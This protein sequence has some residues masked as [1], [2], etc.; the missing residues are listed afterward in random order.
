LST[1][2]EQLS[3]EARDKLERWAPNQRQLLAELLEDAGTDLQ[4]EFLDRAIAA[5]HTP[6]E[7]HAFAD[8]LRGMDDDEAF[9]ACTLDA[10]APEGYTVNQLLR[11]EA[12]PLYAYELKGG[13]LSPA[14]EGSEAPVT[15]ELTVD[16]ELTPPPMNPSPD[17]RVPTEAKPPRGEVIAQPKPAP[18]PLSVKD[19][20]PPGTMSP[21]GTLR[22]KDFATGSSGKLPAAAPLKESAPPGAMTPGGTKRPA[23][24]DTQP[25]PAF[26]PP[27]PGVVSHADTHPQPAFRPPPAGVDTGAH[28]PFRPPLAGTTAPAPADTQPHVAFKPAAKPDPVAGAKGGTF[29]PPPPGVAMPGTGVNAAFKPDASR[30]LGGAAVAP[31]GTHRPNVGSGA[32]LPLSPRDSGSPP[33][34]A[35]MLAREL[36]GSPDGARSRALGSSPAL[37]AVP[38]ANK[39]CEDVLTEACRPLGLT[40]RECDVDVD[41]GTTLEQALEQASIALQRGVMVPVCLGPQPGQHKRFAVLMQLSVVGANRAWQLYEMTTQ[42]LMWMNEGDLLARKELPFAN[43][44]NRRITRFALPNI[45]QSD[46]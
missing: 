28:A 26:R 43:K 12:D 44:V 5:G 17:R 24:A 27:M 9:T 22:P 6:A 14:E 39:L 29:R 19:L 30:E 8:E 36:G 38:V 45:K 20:A 13:T 42:E 10:D 23:P 41:G 4:R 1:P 7:V 3:P 16:Q 18:A 46:F 2:Y 32:G 40:F 11:A 21:G 35:R 33:V 25:H 37:S 15:T 34:P 31:S